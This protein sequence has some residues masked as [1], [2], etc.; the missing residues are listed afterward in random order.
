MSSTEVTSSTKERLA[1]LGGPKAITQD[2][3]DMFTWPIITKE[4]EQAVLEM[5]HRGVAMSGT[6]VTVKLEEEICEYFGVKYALAF[7][8][9]TAALLGAMWAC[10][11]GVGDEIICPSPTYWAASLPALS[12]GATINYTDILAETLCIDPADI[13]HRISAETKAI[14]PVHN[15]AYPAEMDEIMAIAEKHNVK[16]IEDVSHAQGGLYKGRI[17]GAIGHVGAF[18]MM[19][20]KSLVAGEG[21]MLV[22]ND[23]KIYERAVAFG[24]YERTGLA[25][26]YSDGEGQITNPELKKFAGLPMGGYKH[27]LN[28]VASSLARVQLKHYPARIKEIQKAMN[29]FWDLLEGT[30]GIKANRPP[31]ESG[32]TMAGWYAA[33]GL[34]RPEELGGLTVEKFCQAVT[35]EGFETF[36][37]INHPMH[38]HPVLH[39]ADIYGHGKPTVVAH[40]KRDVRQGPG[41]LPVS[42][43]I[44]ERC[45]TIPWFK[46]DRPEIIAEYAAAFRKVAEH[47]DEL[48]KQ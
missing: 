31:A 1:I 27:R 13:E 46:H 11:V 10:G 33:K 18:S 22:T 8:N 3:G 20:G 14:V 40:A 5:L 21:G 37:G 29:R 17:L 7:C 15:C 47:A 6:D 35:A 23:R 28:Q 39:E 48:L 34:Y 30:P 36:G 44:A 38:L 19:A 26:M 41:S 12:L 16:V 42:E 45:F 32:S 9:G 24:H 25:T 2:P 43:S 4:D